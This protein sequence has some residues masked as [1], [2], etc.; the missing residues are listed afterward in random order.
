MT[1]LLFLGHRESTFY[2]SLHYWL[3]EYGFCHFWNNTTKLWSQRSWICSF[4][5]MI[6]SHSSI[7][8]VTK[9]NQFIFVVNLF[10]N[11]MC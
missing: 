5:N 3:R 7:C 1:H 6:I 11:L 10:L 8:Y 9:T 2:Y 4:Y